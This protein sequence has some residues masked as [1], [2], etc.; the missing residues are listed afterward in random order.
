MSRGIVRPW[1]FPDYGQGRPRAQCAS[2]THPRHARLGAVRGTVHFLGITWVGVT[3]QN[4][5]RLLLSVGFL[6]A[7]LIL[8][9]AARQVTRL[10]LRGESNARLHARFWVHQVINLSAA[11]LIFLGLVS[12]WFED[13]ARM[14][15]AF[16]LVS[17]GLAFALQRVVTALAGYVVILR[18]N[19]FTVGDR[20]SMGGVRG[21][22]IALGF[23]QTTLLEMGYPSGG[24]A[25][26][27]VWVKSR[28]FTGRIVTV[29]NAKI[30]DDPVYNYTR[31]FPYIWDEIAVPVRYGDDRA[32]AEAIILEAARCHALDPREIEAE[33]ARNLERH[34][35][36]RPLDFAPKVYCRLTSNW[37]ELTVRFVYRDHGM[38]A[39][40]DLIARDIL[41]GFEAAGIAVAT[42]AYTVAGLPPIELK[43]AGEA[44]RRARADRA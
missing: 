5:R 10:V 2:S 18:G 25:G 28:Q 15:T 4:G 29:S 20:I 14:A 26:P 13:P 41:G 37:V 30:F 34:F 8:R 38:R 3:E 24:D 44:A 33:A 11:L 12:I 16:G 1:R 23:I 43:E 21:D 42:A 36:L 27:I 9:G 7:V 32:R 19:T 31:D 40:K 6:V 22:V 39:V 35:D 17:A